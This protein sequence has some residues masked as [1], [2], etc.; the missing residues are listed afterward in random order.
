MS[1]PEAKETR[2]GLFCV[3]QPHLM[4]GGREVG[5]FRRSTVP[6]TYSSTHPA[7]NPSMHHPACLPVCLPTSLPSSTVPLVP[8]YLEVPIYLV[9]PIYLEVPIYL[10]VP[11]Y[12]VLHIYPEVLTFHPTHLSTYSPTHSPTYPPT[13]PS[14]SCPQQQRAAPAALPGSA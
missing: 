5:R 6:V 14:T 4:G 7:T 9:V 11:V 8:I 13:V 3:E 1:A 12:L 2:W 10:V